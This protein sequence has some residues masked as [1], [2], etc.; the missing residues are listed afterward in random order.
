M[1]LRHFSATYFC[2]CGYRLRLFWEHYFDC[3][4]KCYNNKAA[5]K[6]KHWNI[7]Q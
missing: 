6:K 3:R 5:N 2:V 1:K 7:H 4:L